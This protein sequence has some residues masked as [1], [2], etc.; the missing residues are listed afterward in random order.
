MKKG[1]NRRYRDARELKQTDLR[2]P[3]IEN[4]IAK[5]LDDTEGTADAVEE[6]AECMRS[7]HADW[8]MAEEE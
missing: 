2:D 4:L 3:E 8:C 7:P 5:T 1:K 6:C